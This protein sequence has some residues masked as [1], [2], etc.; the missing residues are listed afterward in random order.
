VKH[1]IV[2][3]ALLLILSTAAPTP[4]IPAAEVTAPAAPVDTSTDRELVVRFARAYGMAIG[5]APEGERPDAMRDPAALE[6]ERREQLEQILTEGGLSLEDW[7]GMFARM[8]DDADL[9]ARIESLS[10]PFRIR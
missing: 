6:D 2:M 3:S 5:S 1:T 10:V 9:R 4:A 7:T 8:D